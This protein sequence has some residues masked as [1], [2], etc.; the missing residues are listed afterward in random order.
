MVNPSISVQ[1][2]TLFGVCAR[3]NK[4]VTDA[5]IWFI[6]YSG[7]AL[8]QESKEKKVIKKTKRFINK[9]F[10][11]ERRRDDMKNKTNKNQ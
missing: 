3:I 8:N 1:K 6:G 2:R 5:R 10:I 11:S 9:S 7:T 4:L